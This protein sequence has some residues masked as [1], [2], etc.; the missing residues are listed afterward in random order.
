MLTG[1]NGILTQAQR[2]KEETEQAEKNEMSDLASMESLIN[3]YQNNINIP[4]VTDENPGQLEKEND[5]TFVINSIEDLVFFAYDVTNGNNYSG[6]TVKLG[7]SLDFNST[8]SYVDPLRTDY[9]KYGY[10]GELKTLLTT[11]EGF[12]PIGLNEGTIAEIEEKSFYGEF[13]GNSFSIY[14]L[15]I[16]KNKEIQNNFWVAGLFANNMGHINNLYIKNALVNV[17]VKGGVYLCTGILAARNKG[18]IDK[19]TTSGSL[20]ASNLD[21]SFNSGGL[22]GA[23]SGTITESFNLA[24]VNGKYSI[25]DNRVGGISGINETNG[26]IN[27]VYNIGNMKAE[28]FGE[29][30]QEVDNLCSVGGVTAYNLGRVNKVYSTGNVTSINTN[31]TRINIGSGI[32]INKSEANNCYYLENTIFSS[33]IRTVISEVGEI[34]TSSEMKNNEFLNLLNNGESNWK[35]DVNNINN[36]YPILDYQ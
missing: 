18:T 19:C 26:I 17:D 1:E 27:N 24:N 34:K 31:K 33:E 9:G 4:Q 10:N 6:K 14:N 15:K 32:G 29:P 11:G 30:N 21:Y 35:K 22:V 28:E 23:N 2:A 7:T 20:N 16:D 3:E 5:T 25:R 36:G 12:I 8:K 13:N